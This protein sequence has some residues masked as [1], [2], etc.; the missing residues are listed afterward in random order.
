VI[1]VVAVVCAICIVGLALLLLR[2]YLRRKAQSEKED[3]K[4]V[5]LTNGSFQVFDRRNNSIIISEHSDTSRGPSTL[6]REIL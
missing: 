1:I 4:N 2:M 6:Q 3:P 5:E